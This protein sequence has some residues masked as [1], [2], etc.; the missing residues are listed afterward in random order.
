MSKTLFQKKIIYFFEQLNIDEEK[1]VK[2]FSQENQKFSDRKKT[3][4]DNWMNQNMKSSPKGFKFEKWKISEEKS[5]NKAIFSKNSFLKDSFESFKQKVAIYKKLKEESQELFKYKYIYYLDINSSKITYIELKTIKKNSDTELQV[6]ITPTKSYQKNELS[7]YLGNLTITNKHYHISVKNDFEKLTFYFILN[8]GYIDEHPLNGLYMGL[9]YNKAFPIS[10]KCLLSKI[11]LKAEK[12]DFY[13]Y[14]NKNKYLLCNNHKDKISKQLVGKY[15][16]YIDSYNKSQFRLWEHEL[17]ISK[18]GKVSSHCLNYNS[19]EYEYQGSVKEI[20]GKIYIELKNITSGNRKSIQFS[21]DNLKDRFP[22]ICMCRTLP[23]GFDISELIIISKTR[24]INEY[25]KLENIFTNRQIIIDAN[26]VNEIYSL[27]EREIKEY[28]IYSWG[29]FNE[30]NDIR[31][32]WEKKILINNLK[33]QCVVDF[34]MTHHGKIYTVSKNETI[35]YLNDNE[36]KDSW[37]ILIQTE[38][39]EKEFFVVPAIDRRYYDSHKKMFSYHLFSKTKIDVQK[40]KDIL[41]KYQ[42]SQFLADEEKFYERAIEIL[43]SNP[44]SK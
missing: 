36:R 19:K 8:N 5:N 39:L 22:A 14:D 38:N 15:Y 3:V 34:K 40:A 10:G 24:L 43:E 20:N 33:L 27:T 28:F 17:V 9:S 1:F 26:L 11:K 42:E 32:F 37:L 12:L 6:E 25:Q 44:N 16:F 23:A 29:S 35:F 41:G 18:N 2:L 4:I 13:L 30:N 21:I 31:K 7:T